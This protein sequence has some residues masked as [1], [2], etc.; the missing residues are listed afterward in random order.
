MTPPLAE[1]LLSHPVPRTFEDGKLTFHR[2]FE[3][4]VGE[5]INHVEFDVFIIF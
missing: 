3:E 5:V 1:T 4:N 2:V